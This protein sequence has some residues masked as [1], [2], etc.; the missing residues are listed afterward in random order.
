MGSAAGGKVLAITMLLIFAVSTQIN[1]FDNQEEVTLEEIITNQATPLGQPT[2]VSIGSYPDGAVEKVSVAIPDG[3][4]VQTMSVDMEPSGLST[5]TAYSFTDASDFS[6]STLFEGVNVNTSSLSL[7]PQEWSWDFESG[8]FGPEWRLGGVS[9]WLIQSTN[10]LSGSQTAK[11]GTISSNQETTLT[12]DVSGIP[13]G[14]GEFLYQVS[15]ESGFDYLVFCIDNTGCTRSSGFDQRWAGVTSGTH[16]FTMGANVQTLTWKYA[17]DGSVNSGSDTAWIDDITIT[18]TGGAGNGI[19]SWTSPAFGPSLTGQGE[20]RSYGFMYMDAYIPADS[21]FE[22]SLL[23]ASNNQVLPG[24]SGLTVT[25]M[26]FGIIDWKTYPLVKMQIDMET[27]TGSLP[28]VHGI[29]F[30][31][32]IEEDF[33]TNPAT[34][35]WLMSGSTWSSGQISGSGSLQ[36]TEYYMRGG[37]V[38]I[39][40]QSYLTGS[41]Q[42]QYSLD[43]G[44]SWNQLPNNTLISFDKPNF[45]IM[46][47]V[48]SS[49]NNW[50]LEK[51]SVEMIRTSV[52]EGLE[53]DIGL[54]NIADWTMDKIGVGKLGLQDRLSDGSFWSV[55]QSTASSP[56][57]FSI[58]LPVSGID[59][60]EFAVA[61]PNA[62]FVNPFMTV[63]MG[64]QDIL[65]SSLNDFSSLTTIRMTPSQL[66]D[67]NNILSQSP[68]GVDINGFKLA[69]LTI[70][71]GSST[72]ATNLHAGG[73][74]ATYDGELNLAFSGSDP[75]IIGIN[76]ALMNTIATNGVREITIPVRMA[77]TGSIKI[78][79]NSLT[80]SPSISPVSITV[81]NV[82]DTFTPSMNW[83]DVKSTFDFSTVGIS[84]PYDYA[85]ANS[86][87]VDFNLIGK[88]NSAQIR[89]SALELPIIGPGVSACIQ[90]GIELIWS[91]LGT[92]GAVMM[93]D[94]AALLEITHRFK[95]PVEWDDEEFLVVSTNLVSSSGPMLPVTKSF[96]LG[97]S[98]GV[99]N[100]ISVKDWEV[101]GL[102]GIGS[103]INYPYLKKGEPVAVKVHLGFEGDEG[104]SPRTGHALVRLLVNGNEYGSSSIINDGVA[105]IQWVV[106]SVGE[107]VELEIDVLPLK[108]QD[109]SYEVPREIEFGF[110]SV[111]PQLLYM[112]IDEFDHFESSPSKVL[113][114]TITDRP[115][116]PSQAE[117]NIWRSWTD[118]INMNGEIDQ[119]EYAT[120]ELHMPDNLM[121]LE[122]VYDYSLD[123]STAPD[124]GYARG[125]ITVA[126][127]AGNTLPNSGNWTNPLF[128][129]LISSD[130]SPQ[131][132]YSELA[133]DFGTLPWLHPGE[134]ISLQIP[135]WDKNGVT[136][137]TNLEFDLS[138]NQ[139]DSSTIFWNR[140]TN[141]CSSSTLYIE[142]LTCSMVGNTDTGLFTNSGQFSVTFQLKWGFDPDDSVTRTPNLI[143]SDLK[144]QSTVIQLTELNWRYS[145][146]MSVDQSSIEYSITGNNDSSSGAWVMARE[147]IDI[148][149]ALEWIKTGRTVN[150]ELQ[151]MYN[152]GLNIA[153]VEYSSGMF[154]GTIITPASSGNYA[155]DIS[156]LNAPNGA[157]ITA[158]TSPLLWFIVDDEA[159]SIVSIDSPS[160]SDVIK[161]EHWSDLSLKFTMSENLFLDEE[162]VYLS[163]EV[164]RSGFG[165]SS[166]SIAN[167]TD[168]IEL[169]GGQ[170]FGDMITAQMSIDLD[171]V[172]PVETRTES[173]E[174][175][176]WISGSDMA[177]N[178]FGSV[179]DEIFSPFA[180]WQLEQQL[181]EYVLTQPSIG[182]SSDV[183]VGTPL[184]LSVV[185]QN[186]GQSDGFAQ[187]R[188]ERVE[189]NGA[190]TIIH[191]QEVK[192][193][194]GGSGFF[195]HRWTPDRDGSM[196]IEFIIVGGPT[197]Q[198]ET[199]YANDGES[200]GFFGGIAEINPVLLIVIFL[201]IASLIGLIAFGLRTPSA[202]NNQRLPP[203]KN[204]PKAAGQIPM[205]Q[206]ESHYA[207]QQVVTSPGDNPYQ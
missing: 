187:L 108:N 52:V 149:G 43:S 204:Y 128:N 60:F 78:T 177:G 69:K 163:W 173:L 118:D 92:N 3:Q 58:Y 95:F 1:Y 104:T 4:V 185:I 206:Q 32:L 90:S 140:Q 46:L 16:S 164:H 181:P 73:F 23:D 130:G 111:S 159:P 160:L 79:V 205:P 18:P 158:P 112:N 171:S 189:S 145:G 102:N 5:S 24:F 30:D 22:W 74:L 183:T 113:E 38:G 175:R 54:D 186:I 191:T 110:D 33:D 132:G 182:T 99:E 167:G 165:F 139:P 101:V 105:S 83:I 36:T 194:S 115:V 2:T 87:L 148:S 86:W 199:F 91:D 64:S 180:V 55:E 117:I 80:Y 134:N 103:D 37:F 63:S 65:T 71:L 193:Q 157:S 96:G 114:F 85:R 29:H 10:L 121:T 178:T 89:C 156:L 142:V 84:N 107:D 94:S 106:P 45:D 49:G 122:G 190:R 59:N 17:K 41:G 82:T 124:G 44:S 15:S 195:N 168:V 88:E 147:E 34:K 9:N 25:E 31:G 207:Q 12:L 68:A 67:I 169:L 143:L 77:S 50:V 57:E 76:S 133:W 53:L 35:G 8:S 20:P 28:V 154:N 179:S 70:K 75:L 109:V 93:S 11:A 127:S 152:L 202:N 61:S 40:S 131:L 170:P 201:L 100:D 176:I 123:T 150:Q 47:K 56:A 162:S 48:V 137:I 39:K 155:L 27:T 62:P 141:I 51:L 144:G 136:D 116:L 98:L 198:T 174:L 120:S 135:V 14:S 146:E 13:A 166:S 81:S 125:W 196:W 129:L 203:N 188:V 42:L 119:G 21:R 161:E 7:L 172:I 97:N 197:S 19:G 184:D 138:I 153:N 6:S 26:D 192:V 66:S 126:D 72:T 151:L 200:D